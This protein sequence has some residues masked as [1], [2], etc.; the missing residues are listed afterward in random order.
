M[1]TVRLVIVHP[2]LRRRKKDGAESEVV[3]W[4]RAAVE[5]KGA[6][7][8]THRNTLV[9]LVADSDELE[10]LENTTRNYLGWKMV[11][12]SAEQLNLSKQQS[13]QADSWVKRLNDT[14]NSNIRSTYMWMVYPEQIDPTRPFELAAE[15]TSDS[16]GKT[17]TERVFTKIKRDGQLITE[18]AP[19]MLGMTLHSE[20]GAL[21]DRVDDMTVGDLWGYFTQYAYMPRLASRTVLDD[22]LRSVID[23]M[24]MPGE[25]FA[26]ATGKDSGDFGQGPG[27]RS[28]L[29][30]GLLGL[31]GRERPII[32]THPAAIQCRYRASHYRQH[33]RGQVGSRQ[34]AG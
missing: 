22:A 33:A 15:K 31:L 21:W 23:V 24:L 26:L 8:R 3:K 17:L 14:I 4:I 9:F 19:T 29:G 27:A 10:R 7:Q 34:G 25:Q 16:D 13:N 20:L 18:L 6:A 32:R 28:G 5:S 11:Q 1:D 30:A 2:R 12:D